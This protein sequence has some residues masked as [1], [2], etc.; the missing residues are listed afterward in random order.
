[1]SQVRFLDD[2]DPRMRSTVDTIARQLR[3][4]ALVRRYR[5]DETNDGLSGDEGAFLMC[6]FWLVDSLAH[7]GEVDEAERLFERLILFA[8]PLGLLSEEAEAHTGELLGNF[9]Q[10][11]T[12]LA[13]VGAAVNIERARHRRL[14]KVGV[15]R[16]QEQLA[17]S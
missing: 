15:P 9:P 5:V 12:H 11:F 14:G 7:L 10:A 4:G 3:E 8:S 16:A 2:H 13:L 1:M 17:G 6:S